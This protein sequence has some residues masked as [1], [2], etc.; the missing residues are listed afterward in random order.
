[1][2]LSNNLQIKTIFFFLENVINKLMKEEISKMLLILLWYVVLFKIS[3]STNN[4]N[5]EFLE[6][7]ICKTKYCIGI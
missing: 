3:V 1:M 6:D 4:L 5:I 7:K 2:T